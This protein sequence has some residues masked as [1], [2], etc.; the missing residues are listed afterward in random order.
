[1]SQDPALLDVDR[2]VVR[3]PGGSRRQPVEAVRGV[4]L[5]LRPGT[6]LGLVGESGCGKS[7]LAAV[8]AGLLR[9]ASGTI[10]LRG[11]V[12]SGGDYVRTLT[13]AR[14]IQMVFQDPFGSLNPRLTIGSTLM[15]VLA[16]HRPSVARADRL[17]LASALL[18]EVG[19]DA[20]HAARFPHELSG[21]QR[22]RVGIARA[23]A[24][25]PE[26]LI[27][28]EPVSALD[29]SVQVQILNLLRSIRERLGVAI[30]F[31]AHDLGA[32]RYLCDETAIMYLGEIVERGPT[33][34]LFTTPAHPYTES[35]LA[36]APEIEAGLAGEVGCRPLL[37]GE[38]PSATTRIEGCPFHPRCHRSVEVCKTLKP[39]LVVLGEGHSSA[40]HLSSAGRV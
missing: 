31:I 30:L 40:C 17:G 7:S 37:R 34:R 13:D 15:E 4:S 6:T 27:A 14:A 8:M 10:R 16:V 33:E 9:P 18:E 3:Y 22:Q 36:A 24:V 26:I 2:I 5:M 38:P 21:G 12:I 19:L 29:V 11:R 20:A 32:V 1:M 35:L 23:L 25:K 28:D 39:E